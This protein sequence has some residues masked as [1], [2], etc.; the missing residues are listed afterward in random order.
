MTD[1][2]GRLAPDTSVGRVGLTV[3]DLDT[4][5]EFYESVVGL[6]VH[7]REGDHAILGDGDTPLL[8]LREAAN[9][10]ERPRKAAGLFHTAV[11][12]PDRSALG[13][14][15]GR[16]ESSWRLSGAAD[17][18]VSEALYTRDP[19]GNGVEIY[20]DRPRSAW[21]EAADG[22]VEMATEPLDT[23]AIRAAA[24]GDEA[25]PADTDIGHVHLEVTD[26]DAARAFYADTLGMAVR[27]T[28]DGADFLAA[29]DY[30]HHVGV[31]VWNNRS[32][33]A[34]GRGLAWFELVLPDAA[35]LT[36]A[37]DRLDGAGYAVSERSDGALTVTD[38]DGIT[39]RLRA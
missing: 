5:T 23:D 8:D 28:Y 11:R 9:E 32:E 13:D 30:H 27:A 35:S 24:G 20:R 18:L 36:A 22:G 16:I 12:V 3:A 6:V 14:A 7:E 1:D 15:L 39:V 29:G 37:R 19:E 17:H 4:V 2:A 34:S 25:V 10:P 21:T 31:N 26:L 38:P 33:P